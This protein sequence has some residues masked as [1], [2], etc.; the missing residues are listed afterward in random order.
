MPRPR[1]RRPIAAAAAPARRVLATSREALRIDG[2][3]VY[4]VPALGRAAA[5]DDRTDDVLASTRAVELFM[6][7][8]ASAARFE[9]RSRT[10]R[11]SAVAAICR[12]LDG[13]PLAIE[14]AAARAVM[15]G[16]PE[17]AARLDDRFAL[18]TGGRRTALPRHQTLRATLDWSYELLPEDGAQV[19]RR[20]GDLRRRFPARRRDRRRRRSCRRDVADHIANLVAKS[21]LVADMRGEPPALPPARYDAR[22]RARESCAAAAESP[23]PHA[24]MPNIIAIFF[25]DAEAESELRP[26]AEWLA[27]YGRHIDNVRAGLDWAFSPTGRCQIGV[28]VDRRRVPLWVQLSLLARMPRA[29]RTRAGTARRRRSRRARLRM[30]LS[31]ARGWSLMYGVGRAREAGPA[32]ATTLRTGRASS[33]TT[34]TCCARC[35]DCASISST[36]ASFA[37]RWNSRIASPKSWPDPQPPST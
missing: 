11:T 6:S 37:R 9:F 5:S 4:R 36:T 23:R 2:E 22:L 32:W 26:Q 14:F 18:L 24:V 35:G 31:A 1:W 3:H 29:R 33:A 7:Q 30:Q 20:L 17:V 10:R 13:I 15:L 21:L 8:G 28:G 25:A 34:T 19:L 12:R 27:V 16:P